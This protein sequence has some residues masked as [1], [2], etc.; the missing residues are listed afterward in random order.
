MRGIVAWMIECKP[1]Q[2][3]QRMVVAF[4]QEDYV[5]VE[6]LNLRRKRRGLPCVRAASLNVP[7]NNCLL[8]TS[9]S[10]RD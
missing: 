7:V 3:F 8:Y 6:R 9:P 4:R 10:P 1:T 5:G 2:C